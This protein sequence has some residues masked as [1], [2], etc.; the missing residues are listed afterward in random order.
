M[1]TMHETVKSV[2][3]IEKETY[4]CYRLLDKEKLDNSEREKLKRCATDASENLRIIEEK[5]LD[6]EPSLVIY[7]QHF[8]PSIEFDANWDAEESLLQNIIENRKELH[9]LYSE[10][11]AMHSGSDLEEIFRGMALRT[12]PLSSL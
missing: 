12:E 4:D 11:S 2:I 5:Y 9:S 7:M 8:I 10:L 1:T 3:R 6:L